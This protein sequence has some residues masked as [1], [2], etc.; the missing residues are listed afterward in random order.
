MYA[1]TLLRNDNEKSPHT[2]PDHHHIVSG[3]EITT[4]PRPTR[5]TAL[6]FSWW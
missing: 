2:A 4:S 5:E 3:I 6:E 1:A